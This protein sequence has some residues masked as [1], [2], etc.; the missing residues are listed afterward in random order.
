MN[1]MILLAISLAACLGNCTLKKAL[2]GTFIKDQ[3]TQHIYNGLT[4]IVAAISLLVAVGFSGFSTFTVVLG[5]L[6][7]L[8]TALQHIAHLKA[9]ELGSFSYTSVI[10]SLSALIPT[11][12]G[13]VIW[14]EKIYPIQI[15]GIILMTGCF[16]L[17]VD[18]RADNK[19]F[20]FKWL[21]FCMLAFTGTGLIGLMQKWHQSSVHKEELNTFLIIAFTVSFLYSAANYL[22]LTGKRTKTD[23]V[24]ETAQK[25]N[26]KKALLIYAP[27]LIMIFNGICIA[28][29]NNLNLYLSGA[30]DSAVFFPIINGGA[31]ILTT[32]AGLI[33]FK[34]KL[35]PKQWIGILLGIIAVILL[36]NPFG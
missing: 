25:D 21:L 20:S 35:S 2:T 1:H 5:V 26:G 10:I 3:S 27:Y 7:G 4:S 31:L 15:V 33:I 18:F 11:L 12:S 16:I 30:M 36:C 9:L 19:Q 34:E 13:A 24:G 32:L 14:G 17:S 8:V 29:N 6:F 23:T 22:L 28:L